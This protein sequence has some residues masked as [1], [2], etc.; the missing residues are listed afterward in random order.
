MRDAVSAPD[1]VSSLASLYA[2]PCPTEAA[3]SLLFLNYFC[4]KERGAPLAGQPPQHLQPTRSRGMSRSSEPCFRKTLPAARRA[5]RKLSHPRGCLHSPWE[6]P[7]AAGRA[8]GSGVCGWE[9][10]RGS[11]RG[12]EEHG[13]ADWEGVMP[14]PSL[15]M[16]A[17]WPDRRPPLSF[18]PLCAIAAICNR[19]KMI[20][21]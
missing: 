7:A 5:A 8:V 17:D 4:F 14:V 1:S 9:G 3:V 21:P 10:R 12:A 2:P 20:Y 15:V 11:G 19:Y 16:M 18:W 6:W 13:P